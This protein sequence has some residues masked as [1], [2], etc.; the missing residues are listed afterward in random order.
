MSVPETYSVII[1]RMTLEHVDEVVKIEKY[2]YK[3]PWSREV[4]ITEVENNDFAKYYVALKHS[5]V[6]GY[7]GMWIILD[8]S[9]VT[10]LAV[11]PDFRKQGLGK[12]LMTTLTK[13]A[14]LLGADRITLEV[15]PSN[16]L[17][18]TLYNSLGFKSVGVKK[19]YYSDNDEDAIIMWKSLRS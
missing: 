17:A 15:R 10:T 14:L 9:H 1:K 7:A 6:I 18:R 11:H 2:S 12:L 5:H 8:E 19:A 3:T 13:E 16:A 4:F